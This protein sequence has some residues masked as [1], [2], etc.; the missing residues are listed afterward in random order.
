[1][2]AASW[3]QL[4]DGPGTG[5]LHAISIVPAAR[6][7]GLA[8]AYAA[9]GTGST[10]IG[11]NPAGLAHE[12]G[13]VYT[14]S[15]RPDMARV[16]GISFAFPGLEGRWAVGASYV[17]YDAILSTDENQSAQ[18]TL[19]PYSLYPTVTYARTQGPRWRWGATVKFARETLGDFEG[20]TPAY[21]AGFD[22][23]VQYLPAVRN[24]GFGAA[25][26]NIGR[27]ITG[28]FEGDERRGSLPGA[29]RAGLWYQ[30]QGQRYLVL[31]ADAESPFHAP[32]L[33]AIGGEYRMLPEWVL[34]A[35][36]RWNTDDLRNVMG[37]VDP[38]AELE[39]RG[40]EAV[41][42]AAGTTVRVGSAS[43]DYAAQW[44][45]ELGL[46]HSLTIAWTVKP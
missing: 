10:S 17:D 24:L 37:W 3:A 11:I 22:A 40:G 41:K 46:V 15:G 27:Q 45:R 2:S 31:T 35:G 32:P 30:P 29:V 28:H 39:E 9:L 23:G 36:T 18:G 13:Q 21:G 7:A 6:P 19:R 16:G 44:W 34:R 26:T 14:G 5:S 38:N 1:M 4:S 20:S 25:V 43:V 8:G 12:T 33:L 42:L